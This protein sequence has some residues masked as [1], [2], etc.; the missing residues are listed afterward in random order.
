M[1]NCADD[2]EQIGLPVAEAVER[3]LACL[4][5][6]GPG[7][8][9]ADRLLDLVIVDSRRGRYANGL[10]VGRIA[11]LGPRVLDVR[12]V[13]ARSTPYIDARRLVEVLV[14]LV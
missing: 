4:Q 3:L 12:L 9:P 6:S 10:D 7:D 2:P 14:S 1:P 11:R 5:R 8:P 13:S